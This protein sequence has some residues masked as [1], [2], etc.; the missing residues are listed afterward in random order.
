MLKSSAFT[1]ELGCET[2][3]HLPV[4]SEIKSIALAS[5]PRLH[6]QWRCYNSADSSLGSLPVNLNINL[7]AALKC[8][9]LFYHKRLIC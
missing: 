2:I 5:L 3:D 4:N 1:D 6:L 7:N 9:C 8:F